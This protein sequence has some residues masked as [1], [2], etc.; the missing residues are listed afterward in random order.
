MS[1]IQ[2]KHKAMFDPM[3]LSEC[4]GYDFHLVAHGKELISAV[5]PAILPDDTQGFCVPKLLPELSDIKSRLVLWSRGHYKTSGVALYIVQLI[6]AYPD[7]RIVIM[8]ATV[9]NTRGLLREIKSHFDGTNER[10]KLSKLFA[11]HCKIG[12]RLGWADGFISPARKRTHLKEA[13]VTVASPKSYKAGQHYDFE[14]FDDLVNEKNYK[15]QQLQE[16]LIEEFNHLTPL[17]EPGGYKTATGTRYSFGDLYGYI[18]RRDADRHEWDTSV[19]NCWKDGDRAKGPLFTEETAPD[20]R[21]LGFT[22]ARLESIEKDD[23]ITF[24]FQYLNQPIAAGRVLFTEEMMLKAC[25]SVGYVD[26]PQL[27]PPVFFIDL[28]SSRDNRKRDNSVIICTRQH[29]QSGVITVCDIRSGQWSAIQFVDNIVEMAVLHRPLMINI[30]GTA[31]GTYFIEYLNLITKTRGITLPVRPIKVKNDKDAKDLRIS[32]IQGVLRVGK[33]YFL[34]GLKGWADL[35]TQFIQWQPGYKGRHDDEIDT[36]SLAVQE[37]TNT[38]DV[39]RPVQVD[40]ML[41]RILQPEEN[42]ALVQTIVQQE[43]SD[44]DLITMGDGF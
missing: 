2:D 34:T 28:A 4:L 39:Y 6:L 29:P 10:S 15:N 43:P 1:Q 25:R 24:S 18:I 36:I 11:G 5:G 35:V 22:K 8:Q 42:N 31:A 19:K 44:Y 9:K 12:S 33:L 32:A 3:F 38:T 27:G 41:R 30:E 37:Y 20:G 13:T 17:L 14:F 26:H 40:S 7:I 16:N 21:V 23:P